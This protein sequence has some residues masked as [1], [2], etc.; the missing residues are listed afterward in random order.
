[1]WRGILQVS[2]SNKDNKKIVMKVFRPELKCK[3]LQKKK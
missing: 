3:H 1:M 2:A